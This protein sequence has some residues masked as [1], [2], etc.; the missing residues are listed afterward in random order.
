VATDFGHGLGELLS[1]RVSN[2]PDGN[3]LAYSQSIF[4]LTANVP[5][6]F[7]AVTQLLNEVYNDDVTFNTSSVRNIYSPEV[8]TAKEVMVDQVAKKLGQDPL[9]FRRAFAR[10]DRMKGVLDAVAKAASWGRS[11]PAGAA[12]GIGV[13]HEYKAFA[14]CVAEIDCRAATVNR[15]VKDGYTGPRMTKVV[16]AVDVGL[17]INPLGLQAQMMGG[18]RTRSPRR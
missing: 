12:Q 4:T 13:H 14:A 16:F 2:L 15:T 10:D 5:Y 6:N 9:Q 7:G 1:A 17:P 3:F 18:S 8:T 11:M